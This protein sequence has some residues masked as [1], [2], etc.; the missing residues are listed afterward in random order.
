LEAIGQNV[1]AEWITFWLGQDA[2]VVDPRLH[3]RTQKETA[4]LA[5]NFKNAS[6]DSMAGVVSP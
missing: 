3:Q 5:V 1:R 4:H 2:N 6:D